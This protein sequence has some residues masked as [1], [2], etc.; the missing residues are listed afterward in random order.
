MQ[1]LEVNYT[2]RLFSEGDNWSLFS[3]YPLSFIQLGAGGTGSQLAPFLGKMLAP[4]KDIVGGALT[5]KHTYTLIDGDN[6]EDKN[7]GR[8][9]FTVKDIG[10]NKAAR[11]ATKVGATFGMRVD[12]I[13]AYVESDEHLKAILMSYVEKYKSVPII[14]NC[15]DTHA[16]R[17]MIHRVV[18]G[19]KESKPLLYIDSGNEEYAGQVVIGLQKNMREKVTVLYHET[20]PNWPAEI[21]PFDSPAGYFLLPTVVELYPD[22]LES[23]E[24]FTTELSCAERALSNPQASDTNLMAAVVIKNMVS[25]LLSAAG[26]TYNHVTFNTKAGNMTTHYINA[27]AIELV[28]GKPA[29][30]IL[31]GPALKYE[32]ITHDDESDER[33]VTAV[34]NDVRRSVTVATAIPLNLLEMTGTVTDRLQG[35]LQP[36]DV[37]EGYSRMDAETTAAIHEA[38]DTTGDMGPVED[39]E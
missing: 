9:N 3:G 5:N 25:N 37:L 33:E 32:D 22:I 24:K 20:V 19:W 1:E 35:I 15:T 16:V 12:C 38:F 27:A 8:Q 31:D 30:P 14:V 13:D 39:T 23:K 11:M 2:L 10:Q 28:G 4:F 18:R 36:E 26:L 29:E 17:R 7:V 6:V 21:S 34:L